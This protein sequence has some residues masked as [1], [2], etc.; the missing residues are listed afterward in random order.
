MSEEGRT[1]EGLP[2]AGQ[3]PLYHALERP[4]YTRQALIREIEQQTDTRLICYV[5]G[6]AGSITEHDIPPLVDLLDDVRSGDDLDLLL[7][8]PGGDV[9]QAERIVVLCRKR[10]GKDARFRVIV[11]NSAKSAGTLI[12]IASDEIVMGE[13]SE[14]G[15]IDPQVTIVTASGEPMHRPAQSF[16]D[17][18]KIIEE[19]A[20]P[21]LPAAYFPLLDKLDP[22][23]LDFCQK[24]IDRSAQFA[25]QYLAKYMLKGDPDR[26]AEIARALNDAGTHLS[27]GALIDADKATEMGLN[28][29]TLQHD[30][31]LW[32]AYW[33]LF[34][35]M[36]LALPDSGSKLLEGR[37][38]SLQY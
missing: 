29:R 33:Q 12:A 21:Q 10:V 22:A 4:R 28:V 26:A 3:S 5:S 19:K 32:R 13:P 35:Q 20:D 36:R 15:P 1:F 18:L 14:L 25:E 37:R 24:A 38:A 16:L 31:P 2:A 23:L 34:C 17:G 8:T 7:H 6:V 30:D 27:H 9:D 11:P